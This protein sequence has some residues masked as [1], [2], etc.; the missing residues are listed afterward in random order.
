MVLRPPLPDPLGREARNKRLRAGVT[1]MSCCVPSHSCSRMPPCSS[2]ARAPVTT[3]LGSGRRA[4]GSSSASRCAPA[5]RG[6]GTTTPARTAATLEQCVTSVGNDRA[7]LSRAT[8]TADRRHVDVSIR[9]AS[10]E[11][12][13]RSPEYQ[14]RSC[15]GSGVALVRTRSE[16]CTSTN[17]SSQ[18][19]PRPPRPPRARACFP[20][21]SAPKGTVISAVAK[22]LAATRCLSRRAPQTLSRPPRRRRPKPT[23]SQPATGVP[24]RAS[25]ARNAEGA[26]RVE[27]IG[28]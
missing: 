3:L 19:Q 17:S 2:G 23:P 28:R 12:L 6:V 22:R 9:I 18:H 8:W 15:P 16:A 14:R 11:R 27:C 26:C 25:S 4:R 21:G 5:P 1:G 7:R 20:L 10:Q 13:A 24:S